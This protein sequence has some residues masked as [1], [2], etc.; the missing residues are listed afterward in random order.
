VAFFFFFFGALV[1]IFTKKI[2]HLTEHMKQHRKDF[3]TLRKLLIFVGR[4]KRL[5]RYLRRTDLERYVT[6][7]RRLQIPD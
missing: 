6:L 4:R 3:S 1:A 5:L 2:F 7:I